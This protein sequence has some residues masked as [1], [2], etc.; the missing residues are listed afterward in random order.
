[1]RFRNGF[2]KGTR[3]S[4]P[5]EQLRL[6][7]RRR[8][9]R[10]GSPYDAWPPSS[11]LHDAIYASGET[12]KRAEINVSFGFSRY[13]SVVGSGWL[14]VLDRFSRSMRPGVR[15]CAVKLRRFVD[16]LKEHFFAHRSLGSEPCTA[17]ATLRYKY[18]IHVVNQ[19]YHIAI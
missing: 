5:A 10:R 16:L 19:L 8:P 3:A 18:C 12:K 9:L 4:G 7:R 11:V 17:E 13:K 2:R 1:M 14:P 15:A 6:P